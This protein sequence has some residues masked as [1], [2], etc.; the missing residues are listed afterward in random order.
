MDGDEAR[1]QNQRNGSITAAA[2]VAAMH[3]AILDSCDQT[4]CTQKEREKE[5][6]KEEARKRDYDRSLRKDA[7]MSVTNKTGE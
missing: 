7:Q 5:K 3:N 6:R 1:F 4:M 2:H